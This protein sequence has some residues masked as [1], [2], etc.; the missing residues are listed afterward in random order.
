LYE[1]GL[2]LAKTI[3]FVLAV[4]AIIVAIAGAA[5]KQKHKKGELEITDLS[6]QFEEIEDEINHSLLSKEQL[7][8][9][10]KQHKK[11]AKEKAKADKK[12]ANNEEQAAPK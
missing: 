8:V 9:K 12:S 3:T 1:Y 10:E 5:M 2:F 11:Q 6:E 4:I 7:K